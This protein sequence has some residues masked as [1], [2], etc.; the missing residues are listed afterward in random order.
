[1]C[2]PWRE[3]IYYLLL[4][5]CQCACL[6]G[7]PYITFLC[8]CVNVFVLTESHI[9]PSC[10]TVSMCLSWR[11]AISYLLLLLCQCVCLDEKPYLTF[12]CYCVNVFV[13]T[14]SHILPS[15]A[16]VSMCLSWREAISYLLVVLC[17]C[18]CL[19]GK[20]YSTFLCYCVNVLALTG[21]HIWPSCATMSKCLSW[22]EAIYY[23][24]VL[25][26]QCV[27][28]DGKP[29]ITFLCYCANVFVLTRSHILPS[30]ATV[31]MCLSWLEAISYLSVLLCQCVCL[32]GKPYITFFCYCVNV[33][34]LTG[35]H[36]LPSCATVSMCLP[37]REAISYLLVLLCQ[38]V[39]LDGKPYITFLCYC[40]NVFVLTR[41][42]ILPSCATVSMCLSWR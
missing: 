24:L 18:V 19:D 29:Y 31:S 33:L 32:D 8:Y 36:I 42:H 37:W 39:C 26:C 34:A 10:A 21:S 13:L 38:C 12:L 41:S 2:L 4:L 7:K 15:C 35:S 40:V 11:E 30:C 1:M 9:L 16:T 22:R 28:L 25:L 6:D 5:L 17:Q 27:C 14:I 23:L 20:P 3:A